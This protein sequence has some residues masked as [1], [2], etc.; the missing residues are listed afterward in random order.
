LCY[1]LSLEIDKKVQVRK[2][3]NFDA[4]F[5][6][7]TTFGGVWIISINPKPDDIWFSENISQIIGTEIDDPLTLSVKSYN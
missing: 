7:I 3:T 1:C 6:D 4:G 5:Y 2:S